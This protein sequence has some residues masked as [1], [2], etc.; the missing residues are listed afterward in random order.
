[1]ILGKKVTILF[2]PALLIICIVGMQSYL[3]IRQVNEANRIVIQTQSIQENLEHILSMLKDAETG[4]RGF[5]LTGKDSYLAPYNTAADEIPKRIDEVASL[6]LNDPEQ[7]RNIE[8]LRRLS[9]DKLGELEETIKLRREKGMEAALSVIR[10]DSGK[11]IMDDIRA[12]I[13][14]MDSRESKLLDQQKQIVGD[15][16]RQS[17]LMVGLGVLLALIALG[18]AALVLTRTMK[19]ADQSP[20]SGDSG[21][22]WKGIAIRYLFAVAVVAAA[23]GLRVWLIRAFGPM[24]LFVTWYPAILLAA[25]VAGGGPGILATILSILTAD[26]W[27]IEPMGFGISAINDA[28]AAGIFAGTG[29]FL[30][31]LAERLKRARVAEAVS[32]TQKKELALLNMGNLMTLDLDH[33]IVNWSEGNRKLYGFNA[34]EVSGQL[35]Y[36]ILRT[37]FD[38][39]MEEIHKELVE[40]GHWEGEATRITKSGTQLSVAL[41]WAL[42][43][44]E[45]GKPLAILEVS[46]DL[47]QQKLAEE[48]LRQQSEELAQQNEELHAQ[49]EE[50]AQQSEELS[51]QNEELL[52]QSEEIQTL[53]V[54]LI[55]R[56]R[57]LQTLLD[58]AH[59]PIGEHEVMGKICQA[60]IEMIG[61]AALGAVVCEARDNELRILAHAGFEGFDVPGSWPMKGSFIEIIMQQDRTGALEDS[62]LRPDFKLLPVAGLARFAAALSSPLHINGKGIGAVSVYSDK[63]QQWTAEQ[64]RLIEWL[65]AKCSNTL[66][67]MRLAEEVRQ[68]QK[69]NEFL[70]DIVESSS[71]AFGVGYPD[72]SLGLINR[73]FE[74]L[75][76][77]SGEELRSID[78]AKALTPPEWFEIERQKLEELH[79]TGFPVRY[80]KEYIRKDGKRLPIELLVH[81]I[82]DEEGQPLYYYSFIN[83][84]TERKQ[85]EEALK[86]TEARWNAAIESFAEGA[87]I[88]TEDEQV[89]YWNPAAQAMH[90]FT[91]EDEGIEP[92]EKTP[93]TFQLWTPDG[94]HMLELDEWPMRRMKRGE[95]VRNL[96]LRIR[97]PDQGWEKVFSYSGA[98]VATAGGERLIFLTCHDLTEL[99]LAEQAL[100]D[101]ERR[102]IGVL[103][104]MPD[105]FVSFDANMRYTYVNANAERLQATCREELMGKDIRIVYPD[106][107]SYK[108]IN[109]YERVIR[110]QKPMTL[111]SYHAGFDRW[112]EVRAFPTP[113]GV[114]VFYKDVSVQ[115][116]AEEALYKSEERLRLAL[117]AASLLAW[118]Y[119]PMTKQITTSENVDS[120]LALPAGKKL[121]NSDQGYALIHSEDVEKHQSLVTEAIQN[122]GSYTSAYRQVRD[123]EVFWL[124]EHGKAIT[125]ASGRTVRLV[126]VTQNITAR[127]KAEEALRASEERLRRSQ[128]VAHLGGWELD[129]RENKLTWSDEV[130]RIFGLKVQEFDTTYEAFLD[131]VHPEDRQ[132]VDNA[133]GSSI[134]DG[135][136]TYEIEHRVI[137]KDNG[138]V[139]TVHEKC[140]HFRD[141]AT[142]IIIRSVGMVHDITE[143][144]L[145]EEELRKSRDELELRV[146]ERTAELSAAVTMLEQANMELQEFTHVTS[147]DLQEPLRKI[148]TFCDLLNK[149]SASSLDNTG[150]EYLDRVLNSVRRM[151]QLLSDLLQLSRIAGKSVQ[152]KAVDLE[153][154]AHEAVDLF[155]EDLKKSGGIVKI[156][157]LP[158]IDAEETQ[159]LRLFQNLIGNAVKYHDEK[160]LLI[161][162][163]SRHNGKT[164]EIYIKDNGIGFEQEFSERI[165]K[166]FQRLHGRNQYEGTGMGL[167]ICRKIVERHGGSIRAESEP[168]KGSTFIITLPVIQKRNRVRNGE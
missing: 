60:A 99:R 148:Q 154:I 31:V 119:D 84:I 29:I 94:N 36:E 59:L 61:A 47:T 124:E 41:L 48:S 127:R 67:A 77:Y 147:H 95:T 82:K 74:A 3:A 97:R 18:M 78:W 15:I 165:F 87:I 64:F 34:Q 26:Y 149:R 158:V 23:T 104:S 38:Q 112:V 157:D 126:G 57:M 79:R 111:T 54:G 28:I 166:P 45:N 135:R 163:F 81:I 22:N 121:D 88:A 68:G 69:Q 142:G 118:D 156:D 132:A 136:D 39:P 65:A 33:R 144:K 7:Q 115:V 89:I 37:K 25:T 44:D 159:M 1:M 62:S 80:E 12:L 130:Y 21:R 98:M 55:H 167:A 5:V 71:Q 107:E 120:V 86:R 17:I 138:E 164:C 162:I 137:R 139:R 58:A 150:Q 141:P 96:E 14:Q 102:L 43:R 152:F 108:T 109:Q 92:L 6:T 11:K 101:S 49:S 70:A 66:A 9:R 123:G 52:T 146:R 46:T 131:R 83:D 155:E 105:A 24:P 103:E 145:M 76:G 90:G 30:S 143:R 53:N 129:L 32:V 110:E 35:T 63:P 114:S 27:F 16:V 93:I 153:K 134:S 13:E 160:S 8:L 75:T 168:G 40:A 56:E 161:N 85:A 113:D 128:E 91:R 116:K 140:E 72:G 100:R 2:V 106:E 73:A 10:Q 122:A 19:L 133:Y 117:D 50:L 151:R 20:V 4:Q 42:R 51:E 125:D